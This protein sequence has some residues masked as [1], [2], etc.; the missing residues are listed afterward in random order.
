MS[1]WQRA[2]SIT[3]YL[4][5]LTSYNGHDVLLN[6]ITTQNRSNIREAKDDACWKNLSLTDTFD[7][8]NREKYRPAYHHTPC[9][10]G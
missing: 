10:D 9:M 2:R 4:L 1:G 8:S 7:I 5:D 6:V 3:L